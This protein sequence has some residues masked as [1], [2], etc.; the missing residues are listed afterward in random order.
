MTDD[1]N[2]KEDHLMKKTLSLILAVLM[3]LPGL[4]SCGTEEQKPADTG[5]NP[6]QTENA[7][8]GETTPTVNESAEESGKEEVIEPA[9]TEPLRLEPDYSDFVMPE[10]T[11]ELTVYGYEMIN[12][13]LSPAL[14]IFQE[15]YPDVK[16]NFV[17]LTDDEF[18]ARI[19]TEVPAGKGPDLLFTNTGTLPDP[20]KAMTMHIFT[21]LNP[22]FLNDAE[23]SF[24][25]Y[26]KDAMDSLLC[27]G[28][29]QIVPIEINLP[30]YKTS[31]ETLTEA[32]IDPEQ[33]RTFEDYCAACVK[34][35][36]SY[37][38]NALFSSGG[39]DDYLM[40]LLS[41]SGMR[42]IDYNDG[43]VSVNEEQLRALLEVCR[44]FH[45]GSSHE[46]DPDHKAIEGLFARMYLCSNIGTGELTLMNDLSL[47]RNRGETPYFLSVKDADGGV[48]AQ[49]LYFA[50]IPQGAANKLNAYRLLKI[51]LSE[52]IQGGHESKGFQINYLRTGIP[53]LKSAIEK[54]TLEAK[55]MFFPDKDE[56]AQLI[57]NYCTS[58]TN[59]SLLPHIIYRYIT[60]ELMPYVR[61]E[62]PWDDCYKRFLNTLELYA[63]E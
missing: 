15:K 8:T 36:E 33:I 38:D 23:F 49:V 39:E 30:V 45:T 12:L 27:Q 3:L 35:H 11:G 48:T 63:S 16:V 5:V 10:E 42:F 58:V 6:A 1:G 55:E 46:I 37:P 51:L 40:E 14:E 54:R 50:A 62:K 9:E 26:L 57:I 21:D 19:E 18:Q 29:R 34:Y 22:Y 41:A 47:I 28:E 2:E 7:Q 17:K 56:D 44:A 59:A 31:V 32:G 4:A 53:V 61:G 25:D 20:F 52:E 13:L 24:D 60:L 43:I